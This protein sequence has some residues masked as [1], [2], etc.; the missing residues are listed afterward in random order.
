[1]SIPEQPPGGIATPI[2]AAETGWASLI[3]H[4][5]ELPIWRPR[6]DD[7]DQ[8]PSGEVPEYLN[9]PGHKLWVRNRHRPGYFSRGPGHRL[10]NP[11]RFRVLWFMGAWDLGEPMDEVLEADVAIHTGPETLRAVFSRT[12]TVGQLSSEMSGDGLFAFASPLLEIPEGGPSIESRL[13]AI[14]GASLVLYFVR[15]DVEYFL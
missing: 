12:L 7:P 4:G 13:K 2:R 6:K 9:K 15:W 8:R 10:T 14:G 11:G 1:M 5:D 3:W